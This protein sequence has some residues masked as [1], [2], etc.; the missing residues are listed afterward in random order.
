M[1][2][3]LA[4]LSSIASAAGGA[5]LEELQKE[6]NSGDVESQYSLGLIYHF[7][8]GVPKDY[9]QAI[10]WYTKAAEQGSAKAQYELGQLYQTGRGTTINYLQA[11]QFFAQAAVQEH[12]KAQYSLALL[13][14]QGLGVGRDY[15]EAIAWLTKASNKGLADAQYQLGLMYYKGTGVE[16]D[17]VLAQKWLTKAALQNNPKAQY[18]LGLFYCKDRGD[19][20]PH[21]YK[22]AVK[23]FSK[24]GA[25]GHVEAQYLLG[26]MYCRAE[27]VQQ[28]YKTAA[29]WFIKAASQGSS[30]A[31]LVL[32]ACYWNGKGVEVDY[33]ESLKWMSLASMNGDK[34]AKWLKKEIREKMTP[35]Q[36]ED[37]TRRINKVI[38]LKGYIEKKDTPPKEEYQ[39]TLNQEI[40][41][42]GFLISSDGYIL[43]AHH[44]V[45]SLE[46]V[47]IVHNQTKYPAKVIAKNESI[48]AAI[49]KVEGENFPYLPISIDKSVQ[50]G[51]MVFT[52]GYPQ[53]SLQGTEPKFTEGSIS[54]LTGTGDNPQFFQISVPV[55]P[56]NSGGPL[57]ND[58]GE[59]IGL[60]VARLND[61]SSL[62]TT[63]TV[64]QNVNYALKSSLILPFLQTVPDLPSKIKSHGFAQNRAAAIESVKKSVIL[65]TSYN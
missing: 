17:D 40:T 19:E 10:L 48:D 52:I 50:I 36:I 43:T 14:S 55:Q 51:D 6:A 27:G 2:I 22:E 31:Q 21:D 41:S 24:A 30:R 42:T 49:L 20:N 32:G 53:I 13:Y 60:V 18:Q 25:A 44:S 1:A 65:I 34:D 5:S 7:G 15:P 11:F 4:G 45:G 29:K 33:A 62:L 9:N 16:Q 57:V 35:A 59:V 56:G 12:A 37:A 58:K 54:S 3:I 8:R 64:S 63:G 26:V 23:W 38:K 47:Q 61:M 39:N 46:T 28:D